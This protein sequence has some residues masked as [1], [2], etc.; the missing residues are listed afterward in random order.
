MSCKIRRKIIKKPV[1]ESN[2]LN[3]DVQPFNENNQKNILALIEK[4]YGKETYD[5]CYRFI[6]A[7][8]ATWGGAK[9]TLTAD[10][11][12]PGKIHDI[13]ENIVNYTK[14]T[15]YMVKTIFDEIG[16]GVKQSPKGVDFTVIEPVIPYRGAKRFISFDV[17]SILN[18]NTNHGHG[19]LMDTLGKKIS[20]MLNISRPDNLIRS[21]RAECPKDI[22]VN[23]I[24]K[25]I[26]DIIILIN[27]DDN[28]EF[29]GC[30]LAP[31]ICCAHDNDGHIST[32]SRR[33]IGVYNPKTTGTLPSKILNNQ[34]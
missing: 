5:I 2:V 12:A 19:N 23:N 16:V 7:F 10:L 29:T 26:S 30:F 27:R 20:T 22:N 28:N 34:E 4:L 13:P 18:F 33:E 25:T 8:N 21:F 6:E 9:L 17:K 15:E 3:E 24:N 31:L 14:L 11:S 1:N 32:K